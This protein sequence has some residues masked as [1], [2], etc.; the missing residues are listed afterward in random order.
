MSE[1]LYFCMT[2]QR[3]TS[4]A[5][6]RQGGKVGHGGHILTQF[7]STVHQ[8][9]SENALMRKFREKVEKAKRY[10]GLWQKAGV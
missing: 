10:I 7:E 3:V 1:Q 5:E 9:E 4:M 8:C 2:C 6:I